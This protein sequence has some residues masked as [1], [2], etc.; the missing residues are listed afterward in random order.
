M[1]IIN[2][3]TKELLCVKPIPIAKQRVY[4]HFFLIIVNYL[5][6]KIYTDQI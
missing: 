4:S 2:F 1:R 3:D 6:Y 5:F